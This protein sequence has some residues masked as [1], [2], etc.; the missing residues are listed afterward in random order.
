MPISVTCSCGAK[1]RAPD[2]AAG[3]T[4]T[5]PKC[6]GRLK[7]PSSPPPA[8]QVISNPAVQLPAN[9][10][11]A[12]VEEAKRRRFPLWLLL[13]FVAVPILIGGMVLVALVA[14]TALGTSSPPQ[15]QVQRVQ[16]MVTV[17]PDIRELEFESWRLNH[18]E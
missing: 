4:V 15:A 7:V 18:G 9:G 14:I 10:P 11:T 5:C 1:L 2:E 6:K 13:V 16:Q 8:P 17:D 3:K 12:N